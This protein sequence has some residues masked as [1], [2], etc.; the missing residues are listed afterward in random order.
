MQKRTRFKIGEMSLK[1][2]CKIYSSHHQDNPALM[3]ALEE[4]KVSIGQVGL[5]DDQII[6]LL[7]SVVSL[8]KNDMK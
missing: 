8:Y 7:E 3:I 2:I 5:S 4:G 1:D 6:F